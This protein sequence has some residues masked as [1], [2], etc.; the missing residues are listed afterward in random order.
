MD[1]NPPDAGL[2]RFPASTQSLVAA[3]LGYS[4]RPGTS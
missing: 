3:S 4:W 1:G 2:A